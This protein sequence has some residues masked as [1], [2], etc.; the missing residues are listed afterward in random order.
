MKTITMDYEEY[1]KLK[2]KSDSII[3]INLNLEFSRWHYSYF[4]ESVV[5]G[6]ISVEPKGK[7]LCKDKKAKEII[8]LIEKHVADVQKGEHYQI[9]KI[10]KLEKEIKDIKMQNNIIKNRNVIQR[11]LNK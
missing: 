8:N 2:E 3:Q 10:I 4:S 1:L 9:E 6:G 7:I 11:I 5:F